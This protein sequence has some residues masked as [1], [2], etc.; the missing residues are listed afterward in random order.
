M[1]F[2]GIVETEI[3]RDSPPGT[4]TEVQRVGFPSVENRF[5]SAGTRAML[6]CRT[7]HRNG[8]YLRKPFLNLE[9]LYKPLDFRVYI[10]ILIYAFPYLTLTNYLTNTLQQRCVDGGAAVDSPLVGWQVGRRFLSP[11]E[12]VPG[13][14]RSGDRQ[15]VLRGEDHGTVGPVFYVPDSYGTG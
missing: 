4:T 1:D 12:G 2:F 5:V 11:T 7:S 6:D 8:R 13:D 14:D 3:A 9:T 10:S 15:G